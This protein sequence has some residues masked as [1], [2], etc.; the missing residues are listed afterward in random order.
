[1]SASTSRKLLEAIRR[2]EH[3]DAEVVR[4]LGEESPGEF[5]RDLIEPLCDSFDPAQAAV[6]ESLMGV[7]IPPVARPAP[8]M[9]RRVETVYVLSRVTL[10]ADIK[11]TSILLDAA[12]RRFP[13]ARIVFVGGRKSAELFA[14]DSRIESLEVSYPRSG[15]V[16]A[17]IAFARELG[18]K[19]AT[20]NSIVL[21]PDSR[22][23]QLGLIPFGAHHFHF[24]SRTAAGE[25]L[26]AMTEVWSESVLGIRGRAFIAPKLV[27]IEGPKP[28][29]AI[30]LGVGENLTKRIPGDFERDLV[31][32]LASRFADVWIDRGAGGEEAERVNA[33]TAGVQV[34]FWEGSFAG[35]ASII[36]QSDLYVGYDSGAQHAA[37]ALGIPVI[38]VFAGAPS[39]RFQTRWA[40]A[41]T[42]LDADSLTAEQILSRIAASSF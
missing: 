15:P 37:A 24:H 21:D 39:P 14:A 12:K 32:L 20:P 27:P 10:G 26:T 34:N 41:G 17:R 36:S 33:A 18:A 5:F 29:V 31:V 23:T 42:L 13:E 11:L 7:F 40:A 1:M 4:L 35:F 16:S 9:P 19:L 3:P 22:L 6:Y 25:N 28:R 8:V 38:T 2:G 30:S